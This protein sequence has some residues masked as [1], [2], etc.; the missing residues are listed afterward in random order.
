M[1]HSGQLNN[2]LKKKLYTSH[3]H[4]TWYRHDS[5]HRN[6][7][8]LSSTALPN[9]FIYIEK[10]KSKMILRSFFNCLGYNEG[11]I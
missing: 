5:L 8:N 4:M 1:C 3:K 10:K 9:A 7:F 2:S 6:N 11:G